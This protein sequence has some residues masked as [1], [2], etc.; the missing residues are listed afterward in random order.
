MGLGVRSHTAFP[1]TQICVGELA[2]VLNPFL[3]FVMNKLSRCAD[4]DSH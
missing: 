2:G 4:V 1:E 3:F